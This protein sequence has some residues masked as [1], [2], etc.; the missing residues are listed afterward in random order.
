MSPSFAR[1]YRATLIM[2]AIRGLCDS[3]Q[4]VF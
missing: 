1:L 4:C 3:C 2:T